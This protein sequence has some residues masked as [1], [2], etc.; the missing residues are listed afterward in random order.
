MNFHKPFA[1]VTSN[2]MNKPAPQ[3]PPFLPFQSWPSIPKITTTLT[4]PCTFLQTGRGQPW[5][6][7]SSI[8]SH[9]APMG[10]HI[11]SVSLWKVR[12]VSS[13][14]YSWRNTSSK[15]NIWPS[16]EAYV[17]MCKWICSSGCGGVRDGMRD[18]ESQIQSQVPPTPK[19]VLYVTQLLF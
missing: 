12:W 19:S 4:F 7:V 6:K 5:T 11:I 15:S 1:H 16:Q 14:F 17:C 9:K 8:K 2:Q 13:R 18:Y 10:L 3:E